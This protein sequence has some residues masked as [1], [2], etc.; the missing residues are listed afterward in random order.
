MTYHVLHQYTLGGALTLQYMLSFSPQ[1]LQ[2]QPHKILH[3]DEEVL[4]WQIEKRQCQNQHHMRLSIRKI[5][6]HKIELSWSLFRL[7]L[8]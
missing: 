6:K 1:L 2:S 3:L 4:H 8:N 7:K 5:K